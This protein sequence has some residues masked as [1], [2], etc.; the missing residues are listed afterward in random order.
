MLKAA[1]PHRSEYIDGQSISAYRTML[2]ELEEN[3]IKQ[4][5]IML[6]GREYDQAEIS[7][8]VEIMTFFLVST[9]I[10]GS[11]AAWYC[12]AVRAI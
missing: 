6:E 10:T 2:D 4:L 11:P 1:L 8:A 9:E 3:I 12:A 5:G 7:R